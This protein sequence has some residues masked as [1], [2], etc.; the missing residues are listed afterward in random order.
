[1]PESSVMLKIQN[2]FVTVEKYSVLKGIN[3]EI[4]PGEVH[5][6]MGPN[7]SGKSTL[8]RVI[9]GHPDCLVEKGDILYEV[10]FKYQSLKKWNTED[11][12]KEGVFM[13]FQYPT[14]VAGV[15]NWNLL[16]AS[17][18]AVCRHQGSKEMNEEQF[19][20]FLKKKCEGV[21]LP[22]SFVHR[23]VN[24]GLSGGEKKKNELLQMAVLSP[25]LAILDEIDSGLDVD[26]LKSVARSL[27]KMRSPRQALLL[28]THYNR[29]LNYMEPDH[30]H[31]MKDGQIQKSGDKSL[32]VELEK[33]GYSLLNPPG[34]KK[35]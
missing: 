25:R 11:R 5:A 2:L 21:G 3:L 13:S 16:K 24:A 14:E 26:S 17:F 28:I 9:A 19:S 20:S 8:A 31:L 35:L 15:S 1:M 23:D 12:V 29:I 32:A 10:N 7:G 33:Q 27:K 30:V 34:T 4:R 22:F 6:L 18:N